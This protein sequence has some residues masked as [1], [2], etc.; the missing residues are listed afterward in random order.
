MISPEL[1]RQVKRIQFQTG[2]QV[3]EVLAAGQKDH[4]LRTDAAA[5][6]LPA[7]VRR[8]FSRLRQLLRGAPTRSTSIRHALEFARR[9]LPRRAI[10]FLI[11]DFFDQGYMGALRT[12]N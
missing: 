12:A 3:A 5:E 7:R 4:D 2:R 11:S 10:L 1:V 6:A 8:W 9:V